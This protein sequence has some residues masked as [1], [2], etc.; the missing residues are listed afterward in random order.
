MDQKLLK[1]GGGKKQT[2]K[3]TRGGFGIDTQRKELRKWKALVRESRKPNLWPLLTTQSS[4]RDEKAGLKSRGR[5]LLSEI[6]K[7]RT[8][9]LRTRRHV[10]RGQDALIATN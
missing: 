8:G 2:A 6:K 3:A 5:R 1:Q 4:L 10:R 9:K 7:N